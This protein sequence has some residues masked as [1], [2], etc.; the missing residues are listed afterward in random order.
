MATD[1][2]ILDDIAGK[3]ASG[4]QMLG[5]LKQG[6]ESQIRGI[7]ENALKQFDVVTSER[8]QLQE[9]MLDKARKEMEQ[10][11]QRISQLEAQIKEMK[12]E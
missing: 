12:K 6:A 5:G 9:A 11:Q 4:L 2:K 1:H 10:L 3:I 7:V 8:M